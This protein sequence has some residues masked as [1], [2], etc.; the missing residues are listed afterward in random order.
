MI[1]RTSGDEP[2]PE[3]TLAML[4]ALT[5]ALVGVLGFIPG[6]TTHYSDLSFAGEDSGAKLLGVFRVSIL[7]NL[8]H[9]LFG[10][11]GWFLARTWNGARIYLLGGGVVYLALW[12]L[13]IFNGADWIPANDA[14]DWL[15]LV[16][17]LGLLS[18]GVVSARGTTTSRDRAT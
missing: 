17:G 16:L 3:R 1:D 4:V 10:V 18:L 8:V 7:H 13:G 6:I 5:F 15:H 9:L 11:A 14:D 2:M 12:L